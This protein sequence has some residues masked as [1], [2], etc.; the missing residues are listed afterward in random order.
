MRSE[1]D[2]IDLIIGVARANDR[3]RAVYMN[4]SRANPNIKK[5][6]FQDYDIVYVV[7]KQN[8]FHS[9][10]I[11]SVLLWGFKP[12][13][14]VRRLAPGTSLQHAARPYAIAKL[15]A[16]QGMRHVS[17]ASGESLLPF[18][19]EAVAH[20]IPRTYRWLKRI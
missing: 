6:I 3:I 17:D 18:V 20:G 10:K 7:R 11:G 16:A 9:T 15:P 12:Q 4:G 8:L 13:G 1:K 14:K 2:M 5:D 19:H